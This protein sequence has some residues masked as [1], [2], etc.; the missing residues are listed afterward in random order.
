MANL[1]FATIFSVHVSARPT[2]GLRM[3][4]ALPALTLRVV[5]VEVV[6]V[7]A[8]VVAAAMAA[9]TLSAAA[10]AQAQALRG[11][12]SFKRTLTQATANSRTVALMLHTI[13]PSKADRV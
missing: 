1:A 11:R 4:C 7:A 3:R 13:I 9:A 2:I 10:A 8:V 5:C 12:L 6:V